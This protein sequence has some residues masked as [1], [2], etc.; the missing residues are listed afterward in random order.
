MTKE[1]YMAKH[2]EHRGDRN[3]LASRKLKQQLQKNRFVPKKKPV[4]EK[5][6]KSP[7]PEKSDPAVNAH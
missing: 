6:S 3:P 4:E 1:A 5:N 2:P 7:D